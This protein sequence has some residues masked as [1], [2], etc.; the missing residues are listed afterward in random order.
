MNDHQS[1][2]APP[3]PRGIHR[4]IA[5]FVIAAL[6]LGTQ[7]GAAASAEPDS[8]QV[9]ARQAARDF[10]LGHFEDAVQRWDEAAAAYAENGDTKRQIQALLGK[11][12]AYLA[13]GRYSDAVFVLEDA[14]A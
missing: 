9:R 10:S 5:T 12:N 1:F 11:G 7:A 13:L 4:L 6:A 8:P 14:H 3:D 2:S